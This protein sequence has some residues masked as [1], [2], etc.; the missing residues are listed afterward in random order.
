MGVH[1]R[2]QLVDPKMENLQNQGSRPAGS[3]IIPLLDRLDIIVDLT[4]YHNENFA[5]VNQLFLCTEDFV[6]SGEKF[7]PT[8]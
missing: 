8:I 1:S 6:I 4:V 2:L 5:D 3:L 7:K